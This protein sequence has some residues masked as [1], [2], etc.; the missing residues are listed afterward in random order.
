MRERHLHT[1]GHTLDH[2]LDHLSNGEVS[3]HI[4]HA[5]VHCKAYR[6]VRGPARIKHTWRT[7]TLEGIKP[8]T[9]L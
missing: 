6:R 1:F 9:L 3:G 2:T 8:Y 5:L 4:F 7:R